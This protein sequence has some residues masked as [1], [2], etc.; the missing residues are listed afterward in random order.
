MNFKKLF[1][2]AVLLITSLTSANQYVKS[3]FCEH[4][5]LQYYVRPVKLKGETVDATVDF[6]Y[7]TDTTKTIINF[8]LHFDSEVNSNIDSFSVVSSNDTVVNDD[9]VILFRKA[10]EAEVR[11]T[12]K[13]SDEEF[14]RIVTGDDVSYIINFKNGQT[15]TLSQTRKYKKAFKVVKLE[16]PFTE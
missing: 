12:S 10:L 9:I 6:T 1:V 13:I 11:F 4:N 16:I 2:V 7:R 8:S 14:E 3:F 5:V 15:E